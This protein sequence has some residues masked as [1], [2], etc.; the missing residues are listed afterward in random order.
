M[1]HKMK[2]TPWEVSGNLDYGRIMKKFG[3]T[4]MKKLPKVFEKE[5]FFRRGFVFGHRDFQIILERMKSKKKF[6]MMTGLMPSG[7]FHFGHMLLAQ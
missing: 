1:K 4:K 6:V 7:K 3:I 5:V 2:V